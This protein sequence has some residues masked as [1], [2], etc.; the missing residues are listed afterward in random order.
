MFGKIGYEALNSAQ[1]NLAALTE[2]VENITN[3][4]SVGYKKKRTTFV[5]TLSGEYAKYENKEFTQGL[6]RKTGELFDLALEGP[7]MFEVELSN[8]QRAYTRAGRF[9]LNSEGELV[10][11]DGYRVIPEVEQLGKTNNPVLKIAD[12]KNNQ[13]GLNFEVSTPKL[14]IPTDVTPEILEDGTVN[15]INPETGEKTKIGKISVVAFNNPQG[16]ESIGKSYFVETNS[17]GQAQDIEIGPNLGIKVK[18][19]FLEFGNVDMAAEF[20]NLSQ[21][22]NVVTAQMKALKLIDKIYENVHYTISRTA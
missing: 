6:V 13:L 4:N 22:K 20:M 11:Q 10:T 2:I 7:G 12:A 16:L 3:I 5:E 8:G 14:I 9:A 18:Q 21:T 19:G 17:S 15:G 1:N